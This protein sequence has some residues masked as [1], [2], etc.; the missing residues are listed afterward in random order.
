MSGP[1]GTSEQPTFTPCLIAALI[2]GVSG[3]PSFGPTY[4]A[5]NFFETSASRSWLSCLFV[6]NWPSKTVSFTFGFFFWTS[7]A[8]ASEAAQYVF[9]DDARKTAMLMSAFRLPDADDAR[10]AGISPA[11]ATAMTT[12]TSPLFIRVL[13]RESWIPDPFWDTSRSGADPTGVA[14][15]ESIGAAGGR[16]R[17]R[18]SRPRRTPEGYFD[19]TRVTSIWYCELNTA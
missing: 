7:F 6:L 11:S 8:P 9:A 12:N 4:H 5:S 13:L 10:V 16:G 1:H 14:R 18:G 3:P 17:E 15:A 19:A 2:V